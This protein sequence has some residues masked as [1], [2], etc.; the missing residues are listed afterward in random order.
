L[1]PQDFVK[2]QKFMSIRLFQDK[3]ALIN[4]G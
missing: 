4:R 1:L 2:K 3:T